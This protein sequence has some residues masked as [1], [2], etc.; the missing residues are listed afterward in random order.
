MDISTLCRKVRSIKWSALLIVCLLPAI[1]GCATTLGTIGVALGAFYGATGLAMLA[2][3]SGAE[4]SQVYYLGTFDPQGQI[5][6]AIY[7][8]TVHGQA[9][10]FSS[11]QF[12]SGWV[13]ASLI[14]PINSGIRLN[15]DKDKERIVLANSNDNI[16]TP[17]LSGRRLV[18]YGPEGFRESPQD[19]RLV[20]V[21]GGDPGA[22]FAAFDKAQG[23]L[24]SQLKRA[25]P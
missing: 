16:Q 5:Q 14:D 11:A 12:A 3:T 9:S 15:F 19:S 7:R 1:S 6:P 2:P 20:I 25:K 4:I 22:L 24:L 8:V 18:L 10:V 17:R 21:M 13:P 23:D